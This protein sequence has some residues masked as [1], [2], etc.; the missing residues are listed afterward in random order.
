MLNR[1]LQQISNFEFNLITLDNLACEARLHLEGCDWGWLRRSW[2]RVTWPRGKWGRV[3]VL[4]HLFSSS[5]YPLQN[6]TQV[7]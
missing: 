2:L 1:N 3:E 4:E 5:F 7:I 6:C